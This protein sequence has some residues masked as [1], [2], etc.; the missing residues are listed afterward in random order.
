[1]LYHGDSTDRVGVTRAIA[2][3]ELPN[4]L[5]A[6]H[7]ALDVGESGAVEFADQVATILGWFDLRRDRAAL[8][9]RAQ[10]AVGVAG[11]DD[12]LQVQW[13]RGDA[14]RI[15]GRHREAE[16]VFTDVLR[17]LGNAP[18]QRRCATLIQLGR[19]HQG[20]GQAADAESIYREALAEAAVLKQTDEVR[21]LIGSL[22][23]DLGSALLSLG[24]YSEA[25]AASA[26]AKAVGN[27]HGVATS[28][29][30][31]GA[32]ALKEGDLG[33]AE[34]SYRQALETF[35]ILG[36]RSGEAL[37][38]YNLGIVYLASARF[39]EAEEAYSDAA[40][41]AEEV[42]DPMA[43][44]GSW[45]G[46]ARVMQFAGRP[47]EAEKWYLKVLTI[48]RA[49][50]DRA[51]E[52]MMLDNLADLLAERPS[53]LADAQ[54]YA[55]QALAIRE[56]L[57]PIATEIWNT[58]GTLG[59]IAEQQ[60]DAEAAREWRSRECESYAAAPVCREMLCQRAF[61]IA[62]TVQAMGDGWSRSGFKKVLA[63]MA[64]HGHTA[65]YDILLR[66]AP[67]DLAEHYQRFRHSTERLL[68]ELA[69][70]A[71]EGRIPLFH[72]LHRILDGERDQN[73]LCETLDREDSATVAMV[74]RGIADPATL[75]EI[76][77]R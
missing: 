36:Q 73:V 68:K 43:A 55:L 2:L 46:V 40:H 65:V 3:R 17:H 38:S 56:T 44:A 15:A 70:V 66:D 51:N 35:R 37:C 4:L 64:K 27:D 54:E 71:K 39:D 30:L 47:D 29:T 52:S 72:A 9:E 31:L 50:G 41:I 42:G 22:Q 32:I 20:Q 11:S 58:Y 18:S 59:E 7:W 76:K 24:R 6:S 49:A 8:N 53:R 1:M 45:S 5:A 14:L 62:A 75:E 67:S 33:E 57:N 25:R 13:S 19:C 12:W 60:G 16:A 48:F 23:T 77:P 28:L 34:A 61:L 74:L 69:D 10:A 26:A 63:D 21:E